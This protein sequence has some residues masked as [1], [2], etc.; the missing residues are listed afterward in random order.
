MTFNRSRK[1]DGESKASLGY[2]AIPFQNLKQT[3]TQ[4]MKKTNIQT[5][6]QT[7]TNTPLLSH[8]LFRDAF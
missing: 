1:E 7:Q 3:N 6:K 8:L 4:K 5:N 2:I